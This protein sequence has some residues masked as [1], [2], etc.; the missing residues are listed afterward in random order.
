MTKKFQFDLISPEAL[1]LSGEV[2][3]V[4]LS[5]VEGDFGVLANHAPMMSALRDGDLV[6]R[7]DGQQKTYRLGG[8][9]ADVTPQGVTVLAENIETV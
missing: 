1:V 4:L 2:E 3:E 8:G 7:Q 6:V 9:F 5:G